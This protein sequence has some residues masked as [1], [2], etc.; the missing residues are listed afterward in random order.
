V[1]VAL[2]NYR[3]F[4]FFGQPT[5][6][7]GDTG[8]AVQVAQQDLIALGYS[9]GPTGAD[10]DFGQNT[11]NALT[12]YQSAMGLPVTGQVDAATW[13]AFSDS[14]LA[15][16]TPESNDPL[17][18]LLSSLPG[19]SSSPVPSSAASQLATSVSNA[20]GISLPTSGWQMWAA[21]GAFS[22]GGIALVWGLVKH[23]KKAKA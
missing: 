8:T 2:K 7:Q 5:L 15:Q 11:E 21:I 22:L 23:F 19:S 12:A 13:A 3:G 17:S 20:T 14:P 4:S 9:V 16:P 18:S 6:S 10:G 1:N